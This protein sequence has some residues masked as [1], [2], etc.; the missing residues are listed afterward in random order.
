[1]AVLRDWFTY[2]AEFLPLNANA[3]QN[4]SVPIQAD[5]DFMLTGLSGTVKALVTDEVVI[6][7]PAVTIRLEN[8]GTGRNMMDRPVPWDNL[9][10]T[11]QR[12][13]L[14]PSPHTLKA[15]STL[16]VA[17]TELGGN[18]R[19]VRIAFLGYKMFPTA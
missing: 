16:L 19:Q 9:V 6:A 7:A 3:A 12:P 18:A 5:S 17:L 2:T 14:L 11:S 4:V 15:N 1:M 13:F 10:G 8:T